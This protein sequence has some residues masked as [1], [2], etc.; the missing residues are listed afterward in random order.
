MS[1]VEFESRKRPVIG[2]PTAV[3]GRATWF[4]R[5]LMSYSYDLYAM[6]GAGSVGE[7]EILL[8]RRLSA[9]RSLFACNL[10]LGIVI[11]A[12][13]APAWGQ[14]EE[15]VVTAR[16][17]EENL[18][19]VPISVTA[20]SQV[21]I[22]RQGIRNIADVAQFTPSV[23]FDE[24]FAQSDTRITIRGLA[25]TRGRQ[26]VAVLVDG[27]D[28]SSEAITSSGGSLLINTRLLDLERVEVIKGPQLALYG[29]AAFAGAIQYVTRKPADAFEAEFQIDGNDE[30]QYS[31]NVGVSF[32]VFGEQLAVRLNGS[33][34]DE[35]GFYDNQLTSDTLADD[36]GWGLALSTR[37]AF[38]NGLTVSVRAEFTHDE[39]GP[40]AQV[41]LPFNA[42]KNV[43]EEAFAA[44]VDSDGQVQPGANIAQC[45]PG[46]INAISTQASTPSDP[47]LV[48]R[49]RRIITP[50]LADALGFPNPPADPADYNDPAVRAAYGAVIAN[51]PSL[52]PYC[53]SQTL[54]YTGQIPDGDDLGDPRIGTDPL[55]P[56]QDY[57]GYDRDFWRVALNLEWPLDKGTFT[58]WSGYLRD[59]ND[60]TQDTN[61]F[62]VPA[63]NIF[64]DGNVNTFSFNNEKTTDQLSF[65]LRYATSF[66]GPIDLTFGGQYWH[67]EVDNDSRS[68]T[69]Q[70]SGSH[71]FWNSDIGV[72]L[73]GDFCPGYTETGALAYQRAAFPFRPESPADRETDHWSVYGMLE[74]QLAET[75]N[76]TLEGR[77]SAEEVDVT[78]PIFY[79]PDAS[80]GPGGLNPCGIFFR[81]CE[82][83]VDTYEFDDQFDAQ[84]PDDGPGLIAGIPELCL[85][86]DP[87]GVQRSIDY[88]PADD[89]NGD[90]QPDGIDTF[91]PWCKAGLNDQDSWLSPKVTLDWAPLPDMLLF[92][93]WSDARK[94]GGFST[95]TIGSS[96]LDRELAEFDPEKMQV[97]ELGANTEWRDNTLRVNGSIFF[98]D[99][100][101]KQ[102]LTSALGND[103]RLVSKI[104]N[105]S[106]A[107]VWGAEVSVVWAPVTSFIGGNWVVSGGYQWLDSEYKEFVVQ[108]GSPVRTAAAG[109]CTPVASVPGGPLDLCE[110]D[111][112]GNELENAPEGAFVGQLRYTRPF[113][114][115]LAFFVETDV[116]WTDERYTDE[117]NLSHTDAFWNSNLRIGVQA[118]NWDVL[119]YIDNLFDDDTTQSSGGG[120]GLGCCFVLGSGLDFATPPIP[121]DAVMVDLPLYR[122]AFLRP[123]RVIGLRA[124]YRFGE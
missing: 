37:S 72:V 21:A 47:V 60:E 32:P 115:G 92:F 113:R 105:A 124:S 53:E 114:R 67:E 83:Y 63:P 20:F 74:W 14:I 65:E 49:A 98:Q 79:D 120:P 59:E 75:W 106:A 97:W 46:F 71:C 50:E 28:V 94:P 62:G 87:A 112:S 8:M 5:G 68:I 66:D 117:T 18:Q 109:N 38:D 36:E 91:N 100:D 110:L 121:A 116:E 12:V 16:K 54:A 96:G 84:D 103:G 58:M 31:A 123:P 27:I 24:S 34:W 52:Y 111:F 1:G 9:L 108:S 86:T 39:G 44:Y 64:N 33:Y 119:A 51:Y 55:H 57:D 13:C 3:V 2:Q 90:G 10:I 99:F 78:G 82:P 15:V 70:A 19:D 35:E 48:E 122:S 45:W 30:N 4:A 43:P 26:N 81:P 61:S 95:L 118:A 89:V 80:G 73:P 23:Q 104:E 93:S 88:G 25:P 101:D 7:W 76:L 102:V 22:E 77:Y 69:S 41:F 11:V 29:R 85:Q 6:S 42:G 40:S 17:R 56:G 107:E